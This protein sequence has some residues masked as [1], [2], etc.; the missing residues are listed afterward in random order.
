MR[1]NIS[2]PLP[3]EQ[4]IKLMEHTVFPLGKDSNF[5]TYRIGVKYS[6]FLDNKSEE[7]KIFLK[8]N[9]NLLKKNNE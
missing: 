3:I 1:L 7:I 2:L 4:H 5:M 9:A 6:K 8:Q